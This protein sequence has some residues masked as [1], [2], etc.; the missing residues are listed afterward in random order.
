MSYH[1]ACRTDPNKEEIIIALEDKGWRVYKWSQDNGPVDVLVLNYVYTWIMEIKKE[2]APSARRLTRRCY[3]FMVS[4]PGP[5]LVC[6]SV[7]V[8][9]SYA[10]LAYRG[11]GGSAKT[12]AENYF[13][14]TG[15]KFQ[16]NN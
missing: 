15:E 3:N 7:A 13:I 16:K 6:C 8:A 4:W 5:G 1:R 9:L 12:S 10:A 14:E 2:G 11:E